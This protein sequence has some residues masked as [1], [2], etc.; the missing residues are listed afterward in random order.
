MSFTRSCL[1]SE[2]VYK[3]LTLTFIPEAAPTSPLPSS[4]KILGSEIGLKY[5]HTNFSYITSPQK[6]WRAKIAREVKSYCYQHANLLLRFS[7]AAHATGYACVKKGHALRLSECY[8]KETF[9]HV[10]C[11]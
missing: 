3:I 6:A 10:L 2:R 9:V 5:H 8:S 4:R 1:N 11:T 7:C